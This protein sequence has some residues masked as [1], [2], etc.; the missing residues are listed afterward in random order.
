MWDTER[1]EDVS[2][3][4]TERI[5]EK[6]GREEKRRGNNMPFAPLNMLHM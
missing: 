2:Q 3:R 6:E 5:E 4:Q 1:E